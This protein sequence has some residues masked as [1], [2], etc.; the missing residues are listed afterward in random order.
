MTK[1]SVI[2]PVYRAEQ[3]LDRCV[4]SL[5]DQ[6]L[7][8][9]EVILVDD[10][11]PDGSGKLCDAYCRDPRVRVIHKENEG[12][13]FARN[14]GLAVAQ[15]TFVAF[16]DADDYVERTMY[17]TLW[18]AA[19]RHGADAVYAGYFRE[20]DAGHVFPEPICEQKEIFLGRRQVD[21]FL[22]DVVSQKPEAKQDSRYGFSVWKALY[23]RD[24]IEA[25]QIRFSSERVL[26]SEDLLFNMDFLAGSQCAVVLPQCFYHYCTNSDSFSRTYR[27]ERFDRDKALYKEVCRRLALH[28]SPE[29][30][31]PRADR[32]LFGRARVALREEVRAATP[33][34]G[35]RKAREHMRAICSDELLQEL[36]VRYPGEQLPRKYRTIFQLMRR[37]A[38]LPLYG[39][40]WIKERMKKV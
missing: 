28:F 30:Y 40:F 26:S 7:Q 11:S 25:Q 22:L 6:T 29:A 21:S 38:I 31:L 16:A 4:T 24:V 15:G 1:V 2:V 12:A 37:K 33:K 10:G 20:S 34:Y 17:E 9:L 39:L 3:Y 27:K 36:Y 32:L 13:G 23:R 8:E 18:A 19:Q 14:S 35:G 5:L